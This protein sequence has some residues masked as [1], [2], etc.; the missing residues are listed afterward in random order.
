MKS[1]GKDEN[2]FLYKKSET[3][4]ERSQWKLESFLENKTTFKVLMR[5]IINFYLIFKIFFLKKVVVHGV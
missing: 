2:S 1:R 5:S 4:K 3:G